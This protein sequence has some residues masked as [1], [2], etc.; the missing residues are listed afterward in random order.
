MA[1]L[2]EIGQS[3]VNTTHPGLKTDDD[4]PPRRWIMNVGGGTTDVN[5]LGTW[6][7]TSA[8]GPSV[9]NRERNAKTMYT[10]FGE[11][12][13]YDTWHSSMTAIHGGIPQL[14]N[15]TS[16]LAKVTAQIS[17]PNATFAGSITGAYY[18]PP[19]F[20]GV[21]SI[22]Y[23][24]WNPYWEGCCGAH[25]AL[26]LNTS[27]SLQRKLTPGLN[28]TETQRRAIESFQSAAL[29]FWVH[30]VRAV[31]ALRPKASVGIYNWPNFRGDWDAAELQ[32]RGNFMLPFYR[33]VNSFQPS[34][35]IG[36]TNTT[37]GTVER[38]T[39]CVRDSAMLAQRLALDAPG[40][41][42]ARVHAFAWYRYNRPHAPF[43]SQIDFEI[44]MVEPF[45]A[46]ADAVLIWGY[47]L[48]AQN[49]SDAIAFLNSHK[50]MFKTRLNTQR[51]GHLKSNDVEISPALTSD[52]A[53][54]PISSPQ[55]STAVG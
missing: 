40:V 8:L 32:A 35:Y 44:E 25:A 6:D 50:D 55:A 21:I 54:T 7:A 42:A 41:T 16:H 24:A 48:S 49:K 12:P 52:K 22:D 19:D 45:N 46:G 15:L 29:G 13:R 3:I 20:S 47:E 43:L 4:A 30:T 39:S 28:S 36:R 33:E 5:G 26:Y 34:V 53:L 38:V 27:I 31:R 1:K 11:L 37:V 10:D 18:L 9:V 14:C 2:K 23:E 51:Y 17:D